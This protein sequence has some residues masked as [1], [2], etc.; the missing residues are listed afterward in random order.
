MGIA[1]RITARLPLQPWTR[2]AAEVWETEHRLHHALGI[3]RPP[4]ALQWMVTRSCDLHCGHCYAEAGRRARGELTTEEAKRLVVDPC[5]EMGCPLLVLAGGELWLRR[6]IEAIIE[7]AVG[8]G[9]EWAMHTHGGHIP[10]HRELLRRHPPS[11][12]AISL[13]GDSERHDRFRG[14]EGC[15]AAV[16]AAVQELV[17]AGCREVVLG[18]TVTRDNA[19]HIAD[20]FPEVV[21]SGAH[22]WGLHLV[23]PEGRAELELVPTPTQLRRIAAFARSRRA[24][25]PVEL[26]NEWGS[27]GI[28]DAYYRDRPFACGAG[29]ISMVVD[30]TGEVMPCTTTDPKESEGNVRDRPLRS[31]WTHGFARFRSGG[32]PA[33]SDATECWL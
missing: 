13:D 22:S 31:I 25:F 14:K 4:A 29:R 9:L 11:L 10:K 23:A 20:M 21:R 26:C 27:A 24:R 1:Q 30:P 32:D 33:S 2:P 17:Q 7:Y 3:V 8:R 5:V 18:T 28:D 6:D 15:H 19:D 12:A 16:L